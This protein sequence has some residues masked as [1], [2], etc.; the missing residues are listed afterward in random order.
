MSYQH[1]YLKY[2]NK[3]LELKNQLGGR[4]SAEP[5]IAAKSTFKPI[6]KCNNYI[7]LNNN[8][9]TCWNASI[10]MILFFSDSTSNCTQYTLNNISKENILSNSLELLQSV[11]PLKIN[12]TI[13]TQLHHLIKDIKHKF[14]IKIDDQNEIIKNEN[15]QVT[16]FVRPELQ[17]TISKSIEGD[18]TDTFKKILRMDIEFEKRIEMEI[19]MRKKK[20]IKKYKYGGEDFESFFMIN[21]LSCLLLQK[22]IIYNNL[23]VNGLINLTLLTNTIGI[24][25]H[26]PNHIAA[27]YV[28]NGKMKFYNGANK[29]IDYNWINLFNK[30]NK[31]Y[32]KKQNFDI[33]FNYHKGPILYTNNTLTYFNEPPSTQLNDIYSNDVLF[34]DRN[35]KKISEFIFLTY[36]NNILLFKQKHYTYYLEYYIIINDINQFKK[37]IMDYNISLEDLNKITNIIIN[38][39]LLYIACYKNRTEIVQILLTAGVNIETP[40]TKNETPLYIACENGHVEIVQ[41]LVNAGANIEITHPVNGITPLYIACENGN[42]EIVQILLAAGANKETTNPDYGKT[43]LYIACENGNVEIVQIL[44]NSGANIDTPIRRTTPLHIACHTG[45]VEIVQI[46]LA[47][48]AN[49]ETT[50]PDGRTPLYIACNKGHVEIVQILLAAGANK[51]T[52][53]P[54]DGIT[55]L[56]IACHKGHV[57]VVQILVN[58]GANIETPGVNGQRPIYI[59]LKKGYVEI[60]KKLLDAGANKETTNPADGKTLRQI[61]LE[62]RNYKILEILNQ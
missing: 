5:C 31:L 59:A 6:V 8:L 22:S 47:A 24:L 20:D 48:G 23:K 11:F 42:V 15:L 4:N 57:G 14:Q 39:T 58:A 19:D 29:I 40:N 38:S 55:P 34:K 45:H 44:V 9:G 3:Y 10:Q 21:L 17:R 16:K 51:E 46:L 54:A 13:I 61:A 43:P 35:F 30:C 25:I 7:I 28:C 32:K 53:N 1:K 52:T 26:I 18:F 56:H 37:Y 41:R 62:N 49:K 60:V 27:F 12:K 2:K 33:Y 36:N 50:D